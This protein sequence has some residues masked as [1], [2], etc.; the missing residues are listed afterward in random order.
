[1]K[2]RFHKYFPWLFVIGDLLV[3]VLGLTLSVALFRYFIGYPEVTVKLFAYFIF[4]WLFISVGR[5]D[6]KIGRTAELGYTLKQIPESLIWLVGLMAIFWIPTQ[7]H[8]LGIFFLVGV[9]VTLV[10][11]LSI[12]RVSVHLLLKQ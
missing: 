7:E 12:Y 1:M 5:R 6:Y 8:P 2:R 3:L 9:A 10:I 11:F 4:F